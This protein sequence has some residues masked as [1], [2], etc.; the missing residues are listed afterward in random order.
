V[1]LFSFKN[2]IWFC[3]NEGASAVSL[4]GSNLE[5]DNAGGREQPNRIAWLHAALH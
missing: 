3:Q 4:S 1:L 5:R 2:S